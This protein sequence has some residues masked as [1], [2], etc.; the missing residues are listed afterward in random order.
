MGILKGAVDTTVLKKPWRETGAPVDGVNGTLVGIADPG[1]LLIRVDAPALY[2]NTN[3]KASPTWT[4]FGTAAV[5][6]GAAGAMAA[7]GTGEA[8]AAG[9][10]DAAARIDH[11]HA[12]GTHDH[13]GATKGGQIGKTAFAAGA[14]SADAPG[15]A[16]FAAGIWTKTE[17]AAGALAADV[18]GRAIMADDFFNAATV[19]A[20]FGTNSIDAAAAADIFADSSIPAGKVNFAFGVNPVA[21]VPDAAVAEGVSGSVSRADHT[22]AIT[23]AAPVDGSLAAA[24]AEGAAATFARADHAHRAMLAD[25]VEFEF[26]SAY[27]A[28]IG[29]EVGDADNHSLVLGL[30][31]ANQAL[32][33]ADKSAIA[34]DWNVA[35]DVHPSIYIHSDTTPATDY[36]KLWHDAT[37]GQIAAVGGTLDL[38]GATEV[39]VNTAEVDVN[40]RVGSANVTNMLLVDAGLDCVSFGA[41]AAATGMVQV[42]S[43][44]RTLASAA[45]YAALSVS[46]A[47]AVTTAGDASTSDYI[48]SAYFAE[49]NITNGGGDTITVAATVYIANAPTEGS[50]NSALYIASGTLNPVGG[51]S[52]GA[53]PASAGNIRVPNNTAVWLA[54]NAANGADI[55]GW[56]VNAA[57]DYEAAADVN[58]GGNK[59]YGGTA[60]NAD[61]DLNATTSATVA[62]SYIVARQMI[63]A[64]TNSLAIRVKAGAI[65]DGE[66]AQTDLNGEMGIDSTNGRLYF[67]YGA[68]W[69]YCAITAGIQIPKD[70]VGGMKI[71][72]RLVLVVDK[73]LED[74][75][76]HGLWVKE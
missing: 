51:V 34:T 36:L 71:G 63:D 43:T 60:D 33:V 38:T 56:K 14:F 46:P 58:L 45:E 2:Q 59:L 13:S 70:E 40:F 64:T 55:T 23:C 15:R 7:A 6:Y 73:Q 62:T 49:P 17:I 11:V 65:G 31:D 21:I 57:D 3:T 53:N 18:T 25:S 48:A 52:F 72:D 47:G 24:N 22:H 10:T 32:H 44:A 26:G 19:L 8:N 9:V 39:S 69:H 29:W 74:G 61:L 20:K 27:N 67:R 42:A 75:A 1:D 41:A 12:L 50:T 28:V 4:Q 68:A 35:A 16:P 76:L 30:A 5:V 37:S 54:R 66:T